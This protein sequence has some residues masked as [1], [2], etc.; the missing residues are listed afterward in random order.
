MA[1][2]GGILSLYG[3]S[4]ET[5][6]PSFQL[7]GAQGNFNYYILGSYNQNTIG[8]ENPTNS[9]HAIHDD[10]AQF[11]GSADLSYIID[12]TSRISLL[13]SG[14]YSDFQIPNNPGPMPARTSSI[15]ATWT[16]ISMSRTTTPYSPT[17]SPLIPSA[18]R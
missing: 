1:L 15:P 12:P 2:N 5:I 9:H 18:F 4:H 13:L 6:T 11:K 17:R 10:T 7:G 14:T 16:K 8:I 3:G